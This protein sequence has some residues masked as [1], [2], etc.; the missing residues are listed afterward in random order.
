LFISL[1]QKYLNTHQAVI[2]LSSAT[3]NRD[4]YFI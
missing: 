1:S 2:I 3:L 4:Y